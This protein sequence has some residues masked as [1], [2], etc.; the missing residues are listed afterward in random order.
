MSIHVCSGV[1]DENAQPNSAGEERCHQARVVDGR[2]KRLHPSMVVAPTKK[3][4][5]IQEGRAGVHEEKHLDEENAPLPFP[6]RKFEKESEQGAQDDMVEL[7]EPSEADLVP[8][9]SEVG[10]SSVL[11]QVARL[12]SHDCIA[13][14]R[15]RR[16][17]IEAGQIHQF[18]DR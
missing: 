3:P 15:T 13:S 11:E 6:P 7:H 16:D 4:A 14:R 5:E 1:V 2:C 9:I 8:R 12:N 18:V 17:E 10:D